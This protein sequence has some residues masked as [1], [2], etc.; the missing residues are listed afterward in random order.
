MLK[1]AYL[2]YVVAHVFVIFCAFPSPIMESM[3][4]GRRSLADSCG[5]NP[6][7][8]PNLPKTH[9]HRHVKDNITSAGAVDREFVRIYLVPLASVGCL[10]GAFGF[11][12]RD[13]GFLL[14]A[15]GRASWVPLAVFWILWDDLGCLGMSSGFS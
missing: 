3:M 7:H 1:Y 6:R 4:V 13:F 8:A 10:W 14:A 2:L 12:W 9:Q 15:F 5:V 11:L